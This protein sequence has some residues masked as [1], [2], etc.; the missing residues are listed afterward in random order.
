MTDPTLIAAS[1]LTALNH[2]K[3]LV[4]DAL[5]LRVDR[6]MEEKLMAI[7]SALDPVRDELLVLQGRYATVHEDRAALHGE[8]EQLMEEIARFKAWPAERERYALR[9]TAMG[10]FVYALKAPS[11]GAEDAGHCICPVCYERAKKSVL[12]ARNH[13]P[14]GFVYHC[15]ECGAEFAAANT[16]AP[17]FLRTRH[18]G[19]DE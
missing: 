8:R 14:A 2:V 17:A 13:T 5:G 16:C 9:K 4:A 7:A 6:E 3:T 19:A 10:V 15:V 1:A 18:D 12:Q 11:D